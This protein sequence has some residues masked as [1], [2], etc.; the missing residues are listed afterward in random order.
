IVNEAAH[1]VT[2]TSSFAA[3]GVYN[4]RLTVTD[5]DGGSGTGAQIDGQTAMVVVYDPSAGFVTG[6]GWFNSPQGANVAGQSI[7]G[8]TSFGLVAKYKSGATTPTGETEFSFKAA[9]IDFQ[10]ST[11]EW[12]TVS[13]A[14]AQ[15][16]GTGTI[17]GRLGTFGLMLTCQDGALASPEKPDKLR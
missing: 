4:V 11:Y 16:R 14:I 12:L 13:G 17:K 5:D 2:A 3:A 6:G 8:K 10:S 7:V 15:Y 1:T 9:N